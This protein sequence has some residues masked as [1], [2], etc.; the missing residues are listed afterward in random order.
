MDRVGALRK[1]QTI[2][3]YPSDRFFRL[4]FVLPTFEDI[5]K[6]LYAWK[7]EGVDD[8]WNYQ[9]EN[10]LQFGALP[11]GTH[12]LRIKGQSS[13]GGWSPHDLAIKVNV[14]KPFYL[15]TWFLLLSFL[16]LI[17]TAFLFYK[18]R[19]RQYRKQQEILETE[20]QKATQQIQNDKAIIEGDKKQYNFKL[21]NSRN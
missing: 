5:D 13:A 8:D 4:K 1:T 16:G 15:Q 9:K 20:I 11:Y 18:R 12:I 19:T 10:T 17:T 6:I 2:N 7:V 14:F 3:F 21:K